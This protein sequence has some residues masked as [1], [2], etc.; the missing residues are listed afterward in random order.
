MN[1][2]AKLPSAA[3]GCGRGRRRQLRP[4]PGRGRPGRARGLGRAAPHTCSRGAQ[5]GT[6][7]AEEGESRSALPNAA[8]SPGVLWHRT[9][10]ESARELPSRRGLFL[11][12]SPFHSSLSGLRARLPPPPP[13]QQ[14]RTRAPHLAQ[15]LRTPSASPGPRPPPL[16]GHSAAESQPGKDRLAAACLSAKYWNRLGWGRGARRASP[17]ASPPSALAWAARRLGS[18]SADAGRPGR[19]AEPP[20]DFALLSLTPTLPS[21][22]IEEAGASNPRTLGQRRRQVVRR[23]P[24]LQPPP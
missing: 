11:T 4:V 23:L 1:N 8:T 24:H 6:P 20:L 5:A 12:C 9:R 19:G 18:P 16:R 2:G 14:P 3:R 7:P 10:R 22:V 21:S 13:P 15:R 17:L